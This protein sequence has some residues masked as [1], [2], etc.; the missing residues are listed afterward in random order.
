MLRLLCITLLLSLIFS[1]INCSILSS[2]LICAGQRNAYT[3]AQYYVISDLCTT[4]YRCY[5]GLQAHEAVNGD[6]GKGR[7]L[8][9]HKVAADRRQLYTWMMW[10]YQYK[11]TVFNILMLISISGCINHPLPS[12]PSP[13]LP[14]LWPS[15]EKQI[16]YWYIANYYNC[17]R[18]KVVHLKA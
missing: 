11:L 8:Q 3:H 1:I 2:S 5:D 9:L 14:S 10:Q 13:P 4:I 12:L 17:Q 7:L 15:S 16:L 18:S 6:G